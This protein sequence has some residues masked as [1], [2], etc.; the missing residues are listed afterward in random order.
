MFCFHS[1]PYLT[2]AS[3]CIDCVA[4]VEGFRTEHFCQILGYYIIII[5]SSS[6][7][8]SAAGI[9]QSV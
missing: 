4:L 6:S 3:S 5:I 8:S 9:A 1:L 2:A 7:S